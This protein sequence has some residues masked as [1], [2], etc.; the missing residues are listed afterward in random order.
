MLVLGIESSC[1]ETA[2]AVVDDTGRVRSDVVHSQVKLHAAYGG[3]VPEL[4]SRDHLRN[5]GPV[6]VESLERAGVALANIDGIAVTNRPGLVGALLVGVQAAKGLAWAAGKPMVGVDHLIGH[7]LAVFLRRGDGGDV[8]SPRFPFVCLLASGGH[9]A[10]YRVS[11]PFAEGVVE[12]GATR[13]DSAGEAFDKV[14]KLLGLEYPGGPA[15]ERFAVLGD[16]SRVRLKAPMA[17]GESLE[18]S[19]SGI[20]TQVAQ[21]FPEGD[22]NKSEADVRNACA[23]FQTA[24]T[25]VLAEK[26]TRAA[27]RE[28]VEDI[29]LS[30]GVAANRELRRRVSELA[31]ARGVRVLAPPTVSC[32]DNAAMIAYAGA[33]R[34]KRGDRDGWDMTAQGETML[35]KR[36][37]KGRGRR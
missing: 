20:K 37:R 17:S 36:T 22:A 27:V 21:L 1:D 29:V 25:T 12:L 19:F 28:G 4:A 11:G 34:L 16:A 18:M 24:V 26:T 35:A 8:P 6:L 30:G 5:V 14:A 7:I 13:D 15:I 33:L 23:A 2:A 9:S 32:T 31:A 3:V 10:L